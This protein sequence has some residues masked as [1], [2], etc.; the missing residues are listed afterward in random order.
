MK[1]KQYRYEHKDKNKP[2]IFQSSK[3]SNKKGKHERHNAYSPSFHEVAKIIRIKDHFISDE[4]HVKRSSSI[5]QDFCKLTWVQFCTV[6]F[7]ETK[8]KQ[9]LCSFRSVSYES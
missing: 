1:T 5:S 2:I 4:Y 8:T 9:K 6:F 7:K 3:H